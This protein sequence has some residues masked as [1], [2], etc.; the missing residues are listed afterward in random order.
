MET[1]MV[2]RK[3]DFRDGQVFVMGT[4]FGTASLAECVAY[5]DFLT[6]KA[7]RY[8]SDSVVIVDGST[9]EV[10]DMTLTRH[11]FSGNYITGT[12]V[13]ETITAGND[14]MLE[15]TLYRL[16]GKV[17]DGGEESHVV[18]ADYDGRNPIEACEKDFRAYMRFR[19]EKSC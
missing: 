8:P 17:D 19:R 11:V 10:I 1:Y 14:D 16:N 9:G 4:L 6:N 13:R 12:V 3:Y 18:W 7:K 5:K 2:C 15:S